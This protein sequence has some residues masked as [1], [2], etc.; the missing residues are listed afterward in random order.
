MG[1]NELTH[2]GIKGMRWGIRRSRFGPDGQT[3][4]RFGPGGKKDPQQISRKTRAAAKKFYASHK[5]E[6]KIA[7]GVA[8]GAVAVGGAALLL[9]N[10]KF[11]NRIARMTFTAKD[12]AA[13]VTKF[14]THVNMLKEIKNYPV[15]KGSGEYAK[16]MR[17][18]DFNYRGELIAKELAAMR[19][20][21]KTNPDLVKLNKG[22]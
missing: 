18:K 16:E 3:S 14:N 10:P 13:Y 11:R 8:A 6:I 15:R 1:P 2:W 20:L 7:G 17:L 22:W 9:R 12:K 19:D 4:S 21:A 5:K